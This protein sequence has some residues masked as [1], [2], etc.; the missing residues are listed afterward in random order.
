MYYINMIA[1][2]Y[3]YKPTPI[4]KSL[5]VPYL[6]FLKTELNFG[7]L[8]SRVFA[9]LHGFNTHSAVFPKVTGMCVLHFGGNYSQTGR[10]VLH[11]G[12]IIPKHWCKQIKGCQSAHLV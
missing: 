1:M 5:H 4:M 2:H 10:S 6:A 3:L 11:F 12:V 7:S 9:C 8:E